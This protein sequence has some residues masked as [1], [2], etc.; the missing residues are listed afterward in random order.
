MGD[1]EAVTLRL[2]GRMADVAAADWNACA[3]STNPFLSHA[4]LDALE[5][6]GSAT[7]KTGWAP[8]HLVLDGP[9]GKPAGCVPMYLK[10]HSYGEYVFDHSWAQAYEHAGG[11]YYPKLQIAVPFTP[12]PG[13][14]FLLRPG[15][16]REP[17]MRT[18]LAGCLEVARQTKVSS[19]HITFCTDEECA[20]FAA[21]GLLRRTGEQF[22]WENR[23]YKT[24]GDF[25]NDLNAR[26]RKSVNKERREATTDGIEIETLSGSA[27]NDAHWDAM[28]G[29]YMDT[30]SRKWGSPY[31]NRDFFRRLGA[32]MADNVVLFLAKRGGRYIAG[33]L[34]LV[35]ADTIYGRYWGCSEDHRFLHFELCYYRAIE[36]AI[37]HG[38]ARVEAGAQGPHKLARG[39]LPK[40]TNSAHWI[41]DASFREAVADYLVRERAQVLT[42]IERLDSYSPFRHEPD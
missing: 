27:L 29:F 25:L 21:N 33:A 6:S 36:Y 19:L 16:P 3:G 39:Y 37:D 22:H 26:K 4:F 9:D 20:F 15:V 7:A 8:H 30:G 14:R 23:G 42:D 41:R 32:T 11:R 40:P 5:Q 28:Y 34:N 18:L 31:L 35:G 1:S 38:L 2:L 13:P 12:V 17:T 10:N 24:F